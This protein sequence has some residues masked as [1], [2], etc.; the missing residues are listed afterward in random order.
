[1][2]KINATPE[3]LTELA[4]LMQKWKDSLTSLNYQLKCQIRNMDGWRDPQHV[5]FLSGIETTSAQI[6][7]YAQAM[8]KMSRSLKIYSNQLKEATSQF[9]SQMGSIR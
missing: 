6:E 2:S 9:R 5:M 8:E 1:M 3:E 7:S 4:R